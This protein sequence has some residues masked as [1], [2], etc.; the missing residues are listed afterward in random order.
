MQRVVLQGPAVP[1]RHR[2]LVCCFRIGQQTLRARLRDIVGEIR[3]E[4]LPM[5]APGRFLR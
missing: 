4:S 5:R 2:K 1:Q 3:S